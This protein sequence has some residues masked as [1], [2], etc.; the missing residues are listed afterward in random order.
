[1][2]ILVIT[3]KIIWPLDEGGKIAT[4]Q[5]MMGL[6]E[7]DCQ[8]HLLSLNTKKH[9]QDPSTLP[10]HFNAFQFEA[11]YI[12]TDIKWNKALLNVFSNKSYNVERFESKDFEN[13]LIRRL[14]K[15]LYDIIQLENLF[16]APYINIIKKYSKAKIILRAHNIEHKIWERLAT[17]ASNPLKKIYLNFLAGRLK[18]FEL[19]TLKRVDAVVCI[20]ESD[21]NYFS[22]QQ[23]MLPVSHATSGVQLSTF[24]NQQPLNFNHCYHLAA[25]DWLP[26]I[27][28]VTW[29]QDE[30]WPQLLNHTK[31]LQLHLAGRAFPTYLQQKEITNVTYH[32]TVTNAA[33]FIGKKGIM[34][35]P[36]KSGG[37]I[38]IK[39]IEAL[40]YG[41][42]V[43]TTSIGAEG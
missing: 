5:L 14:T 29:L 6:H 34:L 16:C 4:H 13:L 28:A 31:K 1:M 32:G 18:N 23:A 19:A 7:A 26:N 8:L 20:S 37:G 17:N 40:S 39:I 38:R 35:A 33:D 42:V 11:S 2:K 24:P 12:N 30:I 43:I 3:N 15:E 10:P 22:S 41:K 25:M 9:F 21:K 36:L 27:E